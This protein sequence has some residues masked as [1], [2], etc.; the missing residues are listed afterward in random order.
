MI[1]LF[2]SGVGGLSVLRALE[3]LLPNES[4]VYFS[5]SARFPYGKKTAA[6]LTLYTT[7]ITSFLI[8][9]NIEMLVVPCHTA[10]TL[11]L[12][13]LRTTF[14][15]PIVGMIEPTLAALKKTTVNKRIAIMGTEGT[16]QSE[17]YQKAI[18]KELPGS[19]LFPLTCPQLERKIELGETDTQELIRNCVRPI[20]GKDVD[21]LLL[22]CT[23]YP[24]V[25]KEIEEELDAGTIVLDP[26]LSVAQEVKRQLK[27]QSPSIEGP[28]HT[29]YTSGDLETFQR[30]LDRFLPKSHFEVHSI[31]LA[32]PK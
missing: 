3:Q 5:D 14:S 16:I 20:L 18:Q 19:L 22:A 30:F 24:H 6:E 11:A 26:S 21:T 12:P 4:F 9:C 29:F 23:H 7:Q 1:G 28:Q 15:I 13:T 25:K 31:R 2:D 27:K 10:S 17:V 8:G 32:I